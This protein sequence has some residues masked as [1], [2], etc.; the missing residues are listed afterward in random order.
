[1]KV[2]WA[3][4][5]LLLLHTSDD[6]GDDGDDDDDVHD[7]HDDLLPVDGDF[8]VSP[9][10]SNFSFV[11]SCN[12]MLLFLARISLIALALEV[13]WVLSFVKKQ[14]KGVGHLYNFFIHVMYLEMLQPNKH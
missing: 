4:L 13:S 5:M 2:C 1:M 8:H 7:A 9:N 10:F 12:P 3:H 14:D 11:S 6:D